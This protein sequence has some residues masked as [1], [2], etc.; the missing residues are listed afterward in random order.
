MRRSSRRRAL[1]STRC[2]TLLVSRLHGDGDDG[3]SRLEALVRRHAQLRTSAHGGQVADGPPRAAAIRVR[4]RGHPPPATLRAL[5]VEAN[6]TL[7]DERR[8]QAILAAA[9]D[10]N[11]STTPVLTYVVN[12]IR[13]GERTIP[14]SLVTALELTTLLPEF[15][16]NDS[17]L[18]PIVLNEWAA[19]DLAVKTGDRVTLDYYVWEEPGRL[20]T[21]SSSFELVAVLSDDEPGRRPRFCAAIS[22]HHRHQEPARLGSAVSDR[23]PAHPRRRR[24]VLEQYRTTPKAFVPESFGRAFWGSRYGE[25]TSIRIAPGPGI[26]NFET[27]LRSRIDPMALGIAVRDVRG[28]GL[29]A[30]RGATNFG[31]YFTYFSFFLVVSALMLTALFFKLGVEQ[32]VR[33]VGLLRAVGFSTAAVRRLFA[34]EG[35]LLAVVGS[36]IGVARRTRLRAA[37][38]DWTADVVGRC[39]GHDRTDAARLADLAR[40]WRRRRRPG[41]T[42]LHLVDAPRALRGL[43]AS[44]AR[45]RSWRAEAIRN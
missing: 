41:G 43:R 16:S 7:I 13:A 29:A 26:E 19:R 35:L 15:V 5:S 38:D 18:P 40:R 36:A 12:G 30:S 34:A 27:Q 8:E 22:G 20:N 9:R 21:K 3:A 44:V 10:L 28:E 39:R 6:G 1:R 11:L 2:N 33:E 14:Y 17:G 32:R 42:R 24:A 37:A 25:T 31:E 23:P 45:W 4:S